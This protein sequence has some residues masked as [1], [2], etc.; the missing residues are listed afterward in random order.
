VD[1]NTAAGRD[2]D[3]GRDR[4]PVH[5]PGADGA[6]ILMFKAHKVPVGRDQIQH[7]EMARDMAAASTT[8]M[9][10]TFVLPEAVIDD[11]VATLPGLDG[12]KMSKSYD[13]TIPLFAAARAAQKADHGHRHRF[14]RAGRAQGH[15]RLGLFQIYQAF[16]TRRGNRSP[17]QAYAEGI[18]WGDAKQRCSSASTDECGRLIDTLMNMAANAGSDQAADWSMQGKVEVLASTQDVK[19]ALSALAAIQAEKQAA[20]ASAN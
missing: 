19:S 2:P 7:I 3:D 1:K 4:R 6:D 10:S 9:A 13:N 11:N 8:C 5:V 16:A 12:R 15:R 14:A 20:K 17:A 18:A